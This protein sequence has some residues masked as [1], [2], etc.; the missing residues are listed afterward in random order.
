[1]MLCVEE[2]S[3]HY[4]LELPDELR[5]TFGDAL[6]SRFLVRHCHNPAVTDTGRR[7]FDCLATNTI[8]PR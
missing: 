6:A 2:R 1:M 4:F 3:L 8:C 7:H 5:L